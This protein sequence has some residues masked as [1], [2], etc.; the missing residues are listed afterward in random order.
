MKKT[1]RS[2]LVSLPFLIAAAPSF[3]GFELRIPME[4]AGGGSMPNGS[5]TF[6]NKAETPP[7]TVEPTEPEVVDPF[8]PENPACDPWAVGYPGNSTGK[9]YDFGSWYNNE[10]L[11]LEYHSCKLKPVS[12]PKLLARYASIIP[13]YDDGCNPNDLKI[14]K[15]LFKPACSAYGAGILEFYYQVTGTEP[16]NYSYTQYDVVVTLDSKWPFT[17]NDIDRIEFDGAICNNL[18]FWKHP[19]T[20]AVYTNI[21]VCDTNITYGQLKARMDKQFM[22]EIYGK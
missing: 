2:L 11:G 19:M 5:I 4:V 8:E 17:M 7:E 6:G 14:Y 20:G 10:A 16:S 15:K 18:R 1:I 22:V 21:F 3:A 13:S 9:D 12:K